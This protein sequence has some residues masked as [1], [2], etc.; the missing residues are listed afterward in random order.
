MI[1]VVPVERVSPEPWRNGGGFTRELLAWPSAGD[2][3]LRISV[4]EITRD[5]AFSAFPG[6]DR[7]LAVV[8]GQG[9]VLRIAERRETLDL[10]SNPLPFD[11]AAAPYAELQSGPTRD[12]NLMARRDAGR[13]QMLRATAD[14]EWFSTAPVRALFCTAPARLQIDDTDAARLPAF[15]LAWSAHAMRQRWRV[16][17]E[18]EPQRA[19]WMSFQPQRASERVGPPQALVLP[20]GGTS[21]RP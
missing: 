17:T 18:A 13:A 9:V 6:V 4:A 14:D 7:W 15:S 5:G 1:E 2:W 21:H 19:L 16:V 10:D 3:Q 20:V 8:E 11:G 12:L